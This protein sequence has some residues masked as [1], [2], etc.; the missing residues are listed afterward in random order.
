MAK[1]DFL[2]WL[3]LGIICNYQT[4]N[5][6]IPRNMLRGYLFR[7]FFIAEFRELQKLGVNL[8]PVNTSPAF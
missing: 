3:S 5:L 2:I 6:L 8:F 4:N 1:L 7:S